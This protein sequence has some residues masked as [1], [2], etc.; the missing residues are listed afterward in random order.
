[1]RGWNSIADQLQA[2]LLRPSLG[3][4]GSLEGWRAGLASGC[5][6][7]G[8]MFIFVVVI[9]LLALESTWNPRGGPRPPQVELKALPSLPGF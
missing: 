3:G 5:Q 9:L 1:M 7:W 8:V 2:G 4:S 6:G